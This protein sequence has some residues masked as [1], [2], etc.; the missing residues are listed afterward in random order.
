LY[1]QVSIF[2]GD[3]APVVE[4]H[5]SPI[6]IPI[7]TLCRSEKSNSIRSETSNRSE[8]VVE[9]HTSEREEYEQ[10]KRLSPGK[11]N[12]QTLH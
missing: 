9:V 11:K 2:P 4:E 7:P 1:L 8:M 10:E 5:L 6:S 3:S 12:N